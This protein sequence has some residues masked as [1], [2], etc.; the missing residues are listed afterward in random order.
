MP[1]NIEIKAKVRDFECFAARAY[2]FADKAAP[3]QLTQTDTFY[4][5]DLRPA[6]QLELNEHA[7]SSA[8]LVW[9]ATPGDSPR[10]PVPFLDAPS[11]SAA[12]AITSILASGGGGR[13]KIRECGGRAAEF[14]WYQRPD[15]A[16]P[17]ESVFYRA[18][19]SGAAS[20]AALHSI[21]NACC[22]APRCVVKKKRL[23]FLA[24]H[25]RIHLDQVEDLGTFVELEVQL[26][27]CRTPEEGA[28]IATEIMSKLC[29]AEEDLIRGAYA[30]LLQQANKH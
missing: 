11:V 21:L 22:G 9:R 12:R 29:I 2:L 15:E 20:I 6:G 1:R 17:K 30:D 27:D 8:E 19:V 14:I 16:G 5:A 26:S 7:D 25:T 10:Y 28:A 4:S 3:Q 24:G 18:C 13:L 23:V